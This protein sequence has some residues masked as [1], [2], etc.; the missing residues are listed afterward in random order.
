M[1]LCLQGKTALITGSGSGIGEAIAKELAREGA[2]VILHGRKV[3]ALERVLGDILDEGGEAAITVGDL[4][5][6][7][8]IMAVSNCAL[9]IHGQVDILV[10]NAAHFPIGNWG[11]TRISTWTDVYNT[12][13]LG[14]VQLIEALTPGMKES[15]WGRVITMASL[16]ADCP[17]A[18]GAHYAAAKAAA[19]TMTCSLAK[20][21]AGTGVTAN[22]IAPGLI[23]TP[24]AEPMLKHYARQLDW[25]NDWN[26][27]EQKVVEEYYINSSKRLGT[28]EDIAFAVA[29]LASPL[30]SYINGTTL[31]VDG[32]ANPTIGG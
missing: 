9:S 10:N 27:I 21:L 24:M 6:P 5:D 32:G 18:M 22:S 11:K 23:R 12:S 15:G 16:V 29:M 20:S 26:K 31:R 4:T 14:S 1:D 2:N 30:A 25:G 7:E 13:V 17:P 8:A 28:P 19:V 3:D